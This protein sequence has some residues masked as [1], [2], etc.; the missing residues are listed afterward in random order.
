MVPGRR[1][2]ARRL[3][4]QRT[5]AVADNTIS[6][7]KGTVRRSGRAVP[8]EKRTVSFGKPAQSPV[9]AVAV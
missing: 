8:S 4:V 7:E 5:V 6:S 1:D 9:F 3:C 2:P